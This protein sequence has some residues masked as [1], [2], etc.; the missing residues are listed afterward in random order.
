MLILFLLCVSVL[1]NILNLLWTWTAFICDSCVLQL[2]TKTCSKAFIKTLSITIYFLSKCLT[3]LLNTP[4]DFPIWSSLGCYSLM[5]FFL[6]ENPIQSKANAGHSKDLRN[7]FYFSL[8]RRRSSHRSCFTRKGVLKNL[9][10]FTEKYL[11]W[12]PFFNKVAGLRPV[13]LLKKRSNTVIFLG[14]LRKNTFFSE[15]LRV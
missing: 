12:S 3:G 2:Y 13:T 7:F 10:K 15:H 8:H 5:S 1:K 11:C 14:I 4:L 9:A 6:Y